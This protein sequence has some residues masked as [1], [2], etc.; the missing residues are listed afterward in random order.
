MRF[1]IPSKIIDEP[2][3]ELSRYLFQLIYPA[4]FREARNELF[5]IPFVEESS[6][7]PATKILPDP[8]VLL[9]D[10]PLRNRDY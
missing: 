2:S 1:V 3:L 8:S 10:W 7:F 4:G 5:K 6:V 9:P